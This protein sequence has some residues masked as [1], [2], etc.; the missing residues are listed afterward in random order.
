[1]SE[2]F[3]INEISPLG[4]G[5]PNGISLDKKIESGICSE[6]DIEFAAGV[7]ISGLCMRE[8]TKKDCG[9]MDGR[10]AEEVHFVNKN[11]DNEIKQTD[12]RSIHERYKVAGGGYITA[13]GMLAG[14]DKLS[15]HVDTDMALVIDDLSKDG[16]YCGT[17][18]GP[19]NH[20]EKS[21][22]GANDNMRLI[23]ENG[24]KHRNVIK[25]SIVGLLD[26]V[27]ASV[28]ELSIDNLFDNWNKVAQND[29]YFKQSSGA[30]RFEKIK[31]SINSASLSQE[32][33]DNPLAVSKKLAGDHQESFIIINYCN[34]MTFSQPIFRHELAKEFPDKHIDCH[35]QAFVVDVPRIEEIAKSV[36]ENTSADYM[37]TLSAGIAYQ[38][39]TAATLTDGSLRTFIVKLA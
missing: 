19:H 5:N 12:S 7:V 9:C 33:L 23:F 31:D 38:L 22:C 29:E 6:V 21:D 17:H 10:P 14:V 16:I 2:K 32:N 8:A 25:D 1:M 27:G 20:G 3:I 30:S 24:V 39:A 36:S 4:Y 18:D 35:T 37:Q 26:V 28:D 15:S 11:G 13:I 34:G